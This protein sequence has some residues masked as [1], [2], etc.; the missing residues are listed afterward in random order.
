MQS[1]TQHLPNAA[2]PLHSIPL[3]LS[4]PFLHFLPGSSAPAHRQVLAAA[5][6]LDG[7]PESEHRALPSTAPQCTRTS[8]RAAAAA[9]AFHQLEKPGSYFLYSPTGIRIQSRSCPQFDNPLFS[10]PDSSSIPLP[11]TLLKQPSYRGSPLLPAT[12]SA[13]SHPA[14]LPSAPPASRKTF[15]DLFLVIFRMF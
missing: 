9:G 7:A 13:I 1:L 4:V 5:P 3:H 15:L 11:T 8:I 2:L 14:S 12:A 10:N 6:C